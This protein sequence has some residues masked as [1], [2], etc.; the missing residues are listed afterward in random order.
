LVV[1]YALGTG[2]ALLSLIPVLAGGSDLWKWLQLQFG[3]PYYGDRNYLETSLPVMVFGLGVLVLTVYITMRRKISPQWLFIPFVLSILAWIA[4]PSVIPYGRAHQ[5]VVQAALENR[6]KKALIKWG[7]EHGRFPQ[8]QNEL[9]LAAEYWEGAKRGEKISSPYARRG[10]PV[11]YRFIHV[12]EAF[13]P[14]LPPV[15]PQEPGV[16]Y[17][18]VGPDAKKFWLTATVLEQEVSASVVLFPDERSQLHV[19]EG[20]LEARPQ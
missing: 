13:G 19:V 20:S 4:I 9:E 7:K 11:P 14:Y 12:G 6:L 16:V 3:D 18:A 5:G 17:Y 1:R 10:Q 2:V 8:T 15:L